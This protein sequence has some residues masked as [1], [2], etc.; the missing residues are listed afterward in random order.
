MNKSIKS[1]F[2]A[3]IVLSVLLS[4]CAPASTSVPPTLTPLPTGTPVPPTATPMPPTAT[5]LL[6]KPT[7]IMAS[8]T[9]PLY[10][11]DASMP[12]SMEGPWLIFLGETGLWAVNSD[13]SGLR[14]IVS[15]PPEYLDNLISSSSTLPFESS[16]AGKWLAYSI[17]G[18]DDS[19]VKQE[20]ALYLL[21]F[22]DLS[23]NKITSLYSDKSKLQVSA[24]PSF[25]DPVP[26]EAKDFEF[27]QKSQQIRGAISL[28]NSLAWS[29]DGGQL[30]FSAA[31]DGPSTDVYVLDIASST[32]VRVT[33]GP[34]TQAVNLIWTPD[35]KYIIHTATGDLGA[36]RSGPEF[37]DNELWAADPK[38]MY[39]H[40]VTERL[41]N[42]I[43]WINNE[44]FLGY[45]SELLSEYGLSQ[46]AHN[47]SILNVRTSRTKLLW[48]DPF[49]NAE[50]D[51]ISK[52]VIIDPMEASKYI[53]KAT[54]Y[55][56][57][58]IVDTNN[59]L[60][61]FNSPIYW[62]KQ[63][64]K[65][66]GFSADR[67]VM[68]SP[69]GDISEKIMNSEWKH[70]YNGNDLVF[71]PLEKDWALIPYQDD[72]QGIWIYQ[73]GIGIKEIFT[74]G[75]CNAI[76]RPDGKAIFFYS[77]YFWKGQTIQEG[78]IYFAEAPEYMPRLIKTGLSLD[79][80]I[81]PQWLNK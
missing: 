62:L 7:V 67:L 70:E 65:F 28:K 52:S 32:I 44:E 37:L 66:A 23:L 42:I 78:S 81:D 54:D 13:G 14:N 15:V 40:L 11:P 35:N 26:T 27:D 4:G 1:V 33:D 36:G 31:L 16:P 69:M 45:E 38:G 43:R 72:R 24:L 58:H 77:N 79:C 20:Q 41:W 3:F 10:T 55:S 56:P 68:I 47:L 29:S 51:P 73:E 21:S 53:L 61:Y 6:P 25:N 22:P 60:L 80:F 49:I 64:D 39:T 18:M 9:K 63:M 30:A 8:Q 74:E 17:S 48:K 75:V 19:S 57:T 2:L 46:E 71:S 34:K 76:W 12:L 59:Q 5:P 50:V